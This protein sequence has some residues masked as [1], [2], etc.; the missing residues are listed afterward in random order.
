MGFRVLWEFL[1]R[2]IFGGALS[3]SGG[4]CWKVFRRLG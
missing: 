3:F 1:E 2:K 4:F